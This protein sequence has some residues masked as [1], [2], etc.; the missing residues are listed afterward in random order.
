M[1]KISENLS[2]RTLFHF[3]TKLDYL[4]QILEHNFRPRYCLED[5]SW[6][7]STKIAK[8]EMAYPMVCF[9][10]IPLSKIKKHLTTYGN[11]GIGLK[12]D[13]GFKKSLTPLIYSRK[14]AKTSRIVEDLINWYSSNGEPVDLK[15]IISDIIMYMKPYY[16]KMYRN[17]GYKKTKFYDEREWRWIPE[18]NR[19]DLKMHLEIQEYRDQDFKEKHNTLIG[20]NY[21]LDFNPS[22]IKYIILNEDSEIDEFITKLEAMKGGYKPSTIKKLTTRI[23]TTEQIKYD[24]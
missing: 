9:C 1:E 23:L 10:D 19:P 20:K 7:T 16:G 8:I 14:N 21:T 24:F 17:A 6:A 5:T 12:K 15:Y 3:T 11:Y 2:A 18:I 13:W 4:I 22:D